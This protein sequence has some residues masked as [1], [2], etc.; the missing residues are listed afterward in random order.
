[1]DSLDPQKRDE[2]F[3]MAYF[4]IVQPRFKAPITGDEKLADLKIDADDYEAFRKKCLYMSSEASP[5]FVHKLMSSA[6]AWLFHAA[7]KT[8]LANMQDTQ[9]FLIERIE[10]DIAEEED[11]EF[12]NRLSKMLEL[13]Q[14]MLMELPERM[15]RYYGLYTYICDELVRKLLA[16]KPSLRS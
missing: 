16:E 6:L 1:M 5:T 8:S 14:R 10:T 3:S 4:D 9:R 7:D 11:K 15:E 13:T 12:R 2:A